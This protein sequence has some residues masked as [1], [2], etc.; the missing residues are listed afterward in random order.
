MRRLA[1]FSFSFAAA[2]LCAGYLPLEENLLPLGGLFLLLLGLTWIPWERTV[3]ERRAVRWGAAGLAAGFL[4]FAGYQAMFWKPAL[5]LDDTTILLRGTVTQWPKETDYGWSVQVDL[6]P[7]QGPD[8]PTLLYLDGQ[9]AGLEPGDRI[10][11]VAHCTRADRTSSGEAITYYTSQGIFLTAQGYGRLDVDRPNTPPLR[12]WPVWWTRALEDSVDRIFPEDAA[13][14]AKALVTGNREDLS[15]AFNTDLRRTGLTHTVAVSG[16]HLAFL[17]GLLSLLLGGSRRLTALVLIPVSIL[18]TL[19]TGCTPSIARA[20]IMII[21]LEI[22]PL[23]RRERDSAT[24]L[25]TALLLLLMQNP[26]SIT[27]AGLQLSFAAVAGILLCSDRLQEYLTAR[28]P[29]G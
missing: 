15:D 5:A 24:A 8:I 4:W 17:A 11:M 6:E 2:A 20:A 1:I 26:F 19:M 22:A 29:F 14:L 18:F 25:G 28:L 23:F 12:N 9:G 21:L 13:P 3:R 7:E 10:Q 27:H 16:S